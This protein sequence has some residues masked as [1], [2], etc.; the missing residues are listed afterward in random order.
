MRK[1]LWIALI[2]LLIAA[3]AEQ[4]ILPDILGVSRII[5]DSNALISLL[6]VGVTLGLIIAAIPYR[7]KTYG[8]KF[9]HSIL[10]S[11]IVCSF[12]TD[13]TFGSLLLKDNK[14]LF[15]IGKRK[16]YEEAKTAAAG[17]CKELQEGIFEDENMVIVRKGNYQVQTYKKTHQK[18]Q[19][20][21]RWIGDCEYELIAEGDPSKVIKVKITGVSTDSFTCI[22]SSS[23][24]EYGR[25]YTYKRNR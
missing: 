7:K 16:N 8:Q 18:F 1:I 17:D 9:E 24:S 23:A 12:I 22:V 11:F 4:L 15:Y 21:V 19:Y 13:V 14:Y 20:T 2:G 10:I 25:E 6:A 5:Y 3:I